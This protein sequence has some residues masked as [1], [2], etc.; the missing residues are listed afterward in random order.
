MVWLDKL[1]ILVACSIYT[2]L[3]NFADILPPMIC[4]MLTG[5]CLEYV[6]EDKIRP[7]IAFIFAFACVFFPNLLYFLPIVV[8]DC[9]YTKHRFI[10]LICIGPALINY[11]YFDYNSVYYLIIIATAILAKYKTTKFITTRQ[12]YY[13]QRDENMEY[14][15]LLRARN[16]QLIDNQDYELTT[17]TLK[18]RD[19]ISKELHDSIGHLLSRSMIQ[20]G[21]LS[22][23]C[24][25]ENVKK[26]LALLKDSLSDGMDSVRNTIHNMR[27][28]AFDLKTKTQ[29]L[30]DNFTFC[31]IYLN[32]YIQVDPPI[33]VKYAFIFTIKEALANI[34][35][36]SNATEVNVSINE[37]PGF[38]QLAVEDNGTIS[39][40]TRK[41]IEAMQNS[42]EQASGMGLAGMMER[43]NKL[44]GRFTVTSNEGF[45]IFISIPKKNL[46]YDDKKEQD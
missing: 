16:R 9:S 17:A 6:F 42:T 46:N 10:P 21:A 13:S 40:L 28:S 7:Y 44:N 2:V 26:G 29:E 45:I 24:T 41:D 34:I 11:S 1:L 43:A 27:D 20:V 12:E 5:T 35:K 22:T 37:Q 14:T 31:K 23:I 19:R 39:D 8:Y 32:Y 15:M 18:E 33:E 25:D 3:F 30:I 36:H 38:Y 4:I